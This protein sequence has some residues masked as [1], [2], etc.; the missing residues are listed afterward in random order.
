[1]NNRRHSGMKKPDPA[2][3]LREG[4]ELMSEETQRPGTRIGEGRH[5]R[6]A[7]SREQDCGM[8]VTASEEL[9]A[10][11]SKDEIS[12]V[13]RALR[14]LRRKLEA[15]LGNKLRERFGE[16]GASVKLG[17]IVDEII[18]CLIVARQPGLATEVHPELRRRMLD[19]VGSSIRSRVRNTLAPPERPA[20]RPR[21]D[22]LRGIK[23]RIKAW[24]RIDPTDPDARSVLSNKEVERLLRDAGIIDD[25][26]RLD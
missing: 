17:E 25:Y 14:R 20:G 11:L 21:R 16:K 15:G 2:K 26:R 19:L 5:R 18:Y 9:R 1:M 22:W 4:G 7:A 6:Q 23:G 10:I 12:R 13:N 3:L 8:T 24:G